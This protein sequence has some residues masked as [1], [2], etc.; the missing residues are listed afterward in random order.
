M[1][2]LGLRLLETVEAAWFEGSGL[3]LRRS[4]RP[5]RVLCFNVDVLIVTCVDPLRLA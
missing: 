1:A 4:G 5:S 3:L 2:F